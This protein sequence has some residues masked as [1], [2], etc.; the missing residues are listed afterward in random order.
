MF[1]LISISKTLLRLLTVNIKVIRITLG[2]LKIT[3]ILL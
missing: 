1:Y 2:M 3:L